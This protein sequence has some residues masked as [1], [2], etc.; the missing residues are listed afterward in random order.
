MNLKS[1]LFL[2]II[3]FNLLFSSNPV[4][5]QETGVTVNQF[6]SIIYVD[7]N[8]LAA[9]L[10]GASSK[11][12]NDDVIFV[13]IADND[14]RESFAALV[15]N[16]LGMNEYDA[17]EEFGRQLARGLVSEHETASNL[18]DAI[19]KIQIDERKITHVA[20]ADFIIA[21]AAGLIVIKI[22]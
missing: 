22:L 7:R 4:S 5:A 2:S 1:T 20:D 8:E 13:L 9:F 19:L 15:Q 6:S 12:G 10:I 3:V 21:E 11:I 18:Y 17:R 16:V 14:G